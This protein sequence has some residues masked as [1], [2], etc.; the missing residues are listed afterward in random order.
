MSNVESEV[1]DMT[2]DGMSME[3]FR[4][5]TEERSNSSENLGSVN[6]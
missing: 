5:I 4:G 2:R 1:G 3:A 6:K